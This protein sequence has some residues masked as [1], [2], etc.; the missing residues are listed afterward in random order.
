M[1]KFDP[2]DYE[3]VEDRLRRF[4]EQYPDGRVT[5]D[6][7]AYSD[8]Q[9]IV[10]ATIYRDHD[11]A[12]MPWATGYAEETVGSSPVNRTSALENGETSAI[13][14]ALA[15]ANFAAKGKRPSREEMNKAARREAPQQ[16]TE[17]QIADAVECAGLALA[18]T[19]LE[20]LRSHW[21]VAEAD[22]LANAPLPEGFPFTTIR[23]LVV[24]RKAEIEGAA[25]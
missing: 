17:Q 24:A 23:E 16:F 2:A 11:P 15:N 10:K 13:G 7:V 1:A 3:P 20:E 19:S 21:N 18:A 22:G 4:Y 12:T 14:R 9:Y 6:L 5:T 8:T 25:A